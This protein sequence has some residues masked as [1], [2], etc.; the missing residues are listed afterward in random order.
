M[1]PIILLHGALGA[2][3]SLLPLQAAL[4]PL[5]EVYTLDFSGHG[6]AIWPESGLSMEIFEKDILR[7]IDENNLTAA[8]LF[9]YSMGG[10]VA[11]RLAAI[12]PQCVLSVTT[13][14]TK[15][16]WTE[17]AC[18]KEASMLNADVLEAKVPKFVA[19]L[20]AAHPATG[21]RKLVEGTQKMIGGMSRYR[22]GNATLAAIQHPVRLMVGDR[23]KMVTMEETIA[24]YHALRNASLAVLPGTPHPLD[25]ADA[26]LLAKLVLGNIAAG[27]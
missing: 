13:L 5:A 26:G 18:A 1:P 2:A 14:A 11:L 27:A 17:E 19:A 7:L 10:F 21:W 25:A 3:S 6:E 20:S 23:D 9:G 15:M 22:F 8:H 4:A 24:A 12:A 16:D